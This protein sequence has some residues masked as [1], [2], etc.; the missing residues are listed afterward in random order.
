MNGA[1]AELLD[2]SDR[3]PKGVALAVIHRGRESAIAIDS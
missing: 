2:I 1:E 3:A